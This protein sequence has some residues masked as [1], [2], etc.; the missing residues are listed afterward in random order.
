MVVLVVEE[1]A[2]TVH[3]GKGADIRVVGSIM[4][5]LEEGEVPS[6]MV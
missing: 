4:T 3:L 2:R 6:W 1:L 5:S